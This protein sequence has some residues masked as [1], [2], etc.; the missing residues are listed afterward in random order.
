[1]LALVGA[2][3]LVGLSAKGTVTAEML[4]PMAR[5]P[6]VFALAN[7]DPEVDPVAASEHAAVASA[8]EN[9]RRDIDRVPVMLGR[10]PGYRTAPAGRRRAAA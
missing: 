5:D 3:V 2:D 4:K 8:S 9:I 1:M 10:L 6:I 7:P